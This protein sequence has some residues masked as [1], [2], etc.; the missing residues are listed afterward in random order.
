MLPLLA[1]LILAAAADPAGASEPGIAVDFDT[2]VL[3]ILTRS[4]CNAGACHGA[5]AGRGGF[6]LSLYGGDPA[7]DYAAIARELKGRRVNPGRPNDS[8]LLLKS[9]ESIGHGGGP[10]L[11]FDG[12]AHRLLRRWI[13]AGA[14]R[15]P[16]RSLIG[17]T[18]TPERRTVPVNQATPLRALAQ[19]DDGTERDVTRWTSFTAEDPAVV[20]VEADAD[21][22]APTAAA[23]RPGRHVVVA[24]H[25]DRVHAVELIA[26]RVGAAPDL[27]A[28]GR[29]NFID[30]HVLA[31]LADLHL[32]A[33]PPAGDA[34]FLRRV[35]LGLTGRL[36]TPAIAET[37]LADRDPDK[38]AKRVDALLASEAFV[39]YWTHQLAELL[40][41]RPRE[42]GGADAQAYHEWLADRLRE[43]AGLD[44][45]VRAALRATGDARENGP[46]NFHRVGGDPRGR[47]EFVS[48]ALMG[49]R[50]R[51]ANCHNHPLDRWTQDDFHGLAA[52]LARFK[53]GSVVRPDPGAEVLHPGTGEPARPKL[54]GGAYLAAGDDGPEALA[55]WLVSPENPYLAEAFVNR[56]WKALIGRGLVE[57]ADDF[58][59][60]NPATH[61]ALLKELAN[62]FVAHGYDLRHTLRTIALSAAYARSAAALPGNAADD[63]F[64]SHFPRTPLPPAALADAVT[65]V[66][67]VG[68]RY[69]DAPPG[70]RAVELADATA[71]SLTLDLLG[72]CGREESCE[73]TAT[74]DGLR[75]GLH[76]F[77]GPWLNA[78]ITAPNGRLRT[79]LAAGTSPEKIVERF[80]L[81]ALTRKPTASEAA[82]WTAELAG[83]SDEAARTTF[84]E[85]FVWGLLTCDEFVTNH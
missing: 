39:Q 79:L 46:P 63:R 41:V 40:R 18:V 37:F 24:R 16:S 85:D 42:P 51:C 31:A 55:D 5:A 58:R 78:R 10:V 32:P 7:A 25:R 65:D 75:K 33:S 60:T 47:A 67:G 69:G 30:D 62:D 66:L 72:R 34:A 74:P 76:L 70:T 83:I 64:L 50:L 54:P 61:P 21:P 71:A 29:A 14:V 26:P 52:S 3:P 28:V 11:E 1:L 15:S 13:A 8:L 73:S 49:V 17:L 19:Y 36:P 35:T 59:A 53:A 43:G 45:I 2:D 77:N 6:S 68:E 12:Q 23:L 44:S 80:Y 20:R 4:G 27:S 82:H 38:R 57:P 84:L 48:E 81:V 22:A 56:L 9:T